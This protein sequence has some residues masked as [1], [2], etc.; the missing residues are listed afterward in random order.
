MENWFGSSHDAQI[1]A[2]ASG[3]GIVS[4]MRALTGAAA[5]AQIAKPSNGAAEGHLLS[6]MGHPVTTATLVALA[7]AEAIADKLPSTPK[8][9]ASIGLIARVISGAICGATICS[10]KKRSVVVGLFAGVF[11]ALGGTFAAY[12]VRRQL[13]SELGLPD[14]G[15]A[16]M[17]DAAAIWIA[18]TILR[19]LKLKQA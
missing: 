15:V 5:V 3:M 9:T 8:R 6:G 19:N 1:Y 4:G 7:V 11:G 16:L 14:F 13:T 12:E 18:T 10:A 17:E 2:S